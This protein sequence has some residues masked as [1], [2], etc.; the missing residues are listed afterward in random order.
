MAI[1]Q[2]GGGREAKKKIF[3]W[4]SNLGGFRLGRSRI[5]FQQKKKTLT[6]KKNSGARKSLLTMRDLLVGAASF[7]F[8][9]FHLKSNC[10][11]DSYCP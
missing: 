8:M 1:S 3:C 4:T 2:Q 11:M 10:P 7:G 9:T 6:E 5:N